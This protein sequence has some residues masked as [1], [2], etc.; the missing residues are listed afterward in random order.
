MLYIPNNQT[1]NIKDQHIKTY[2]D[3]RKDSIQKAFLIK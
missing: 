2:K 1:Q 3:T